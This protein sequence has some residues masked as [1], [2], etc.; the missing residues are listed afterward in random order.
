MTESSVIFTFMEVFM[1]IKRPSDTLI[2]CLIDTFAAGL[3]AHAAFF[4]G[5]LSFHDDVVCTYDVGA[6][7]IFGRFTLGLLGKLTRLPFGGSNYS[8]PWF[9]GFVSLLFLALSVC[10]G[11]FCAPALLFSRF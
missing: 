9:G 5:N 8:L 4:F 1:K 6:T 7:H 10:S 11:F 2:T 3:A